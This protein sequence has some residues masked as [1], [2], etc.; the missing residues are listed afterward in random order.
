MLFFFFGVLSPR[1]G[2]EV[3]LEAFSE[4]RKK[5]KNLVLVIGGGESKNY[6]GYYKELLSLC[7]KLK[8]KENVIFT[9]T[10]QDD[11]IHSLFKLA[12]IA[13]FPYKRSIVSAAMTWAMQHGTPVI[14]TR[15]PAFYE[16]FVDGKE[17]ILID[18]DHP[19]SL[20]N[21]I[22]LLV[23]KQDLRR[24][25]SENLYKRALLSSWEIVAQKH[26]KTFTE[27]IN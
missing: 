13:V 27:L 4:I 8:L 17:I 18:I 25:L 20:S 15:T 14:A 7:Q 24:N 19:G 11:D 1:K 3:L 6:K 16:N 26:L 5:Y 12:K 10:L 2:I 22:S 23:D 21:A 9:G